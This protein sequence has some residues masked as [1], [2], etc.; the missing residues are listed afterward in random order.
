MGCEGDADAS[1]RQSR[2]DRRLEH[3]AEEHE[4]CSAPGDVTHEE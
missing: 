4:S 3:P 2:L 1:D